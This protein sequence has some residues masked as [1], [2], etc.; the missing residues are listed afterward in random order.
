MT[1]AAPKHGVAQQNRGTLFVEDATVIDVRAFPG[2]QFVI[3]LASPRCAAKATPGSFIH[4]QCDESIPMRRPLS[5]MRVSADEGW[6]EVLFKIVGEGLRALARK[7]A[8]D[9][10]SSIGPIG[11]GFTPDPARPR[12][13]LIGGGGGIPPMVFLAEYLKDDSLEWQPLVIM[14]SEIPFPFEIERSSIATPWL[15]EEIVGTMPLMERWGVAARLASLAEFDGTYRGYV[16][17]LARE[18]LLS[19]SQDALNEVG[20]FSCGPTPMLEAV[21]ALAREFGLPCQVSLEE[22][23]ACAVGGCAGCTVL[24]QTD[25]GP[26]MK[27][28]CVDGPVFEAA[29]VFPE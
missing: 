1:E 26:A 2:D 23:M 6:I 29:T 28:V 18:W 3:R 5:I 21:A 19:L 7:E 15:D 27:R 16:T 24:V 14:G 8:G 4:V 22:F 25:D 11:R 9:A 17:D 13:L 12:T 10:V 20:L